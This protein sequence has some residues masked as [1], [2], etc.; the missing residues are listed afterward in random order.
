MHAKGD[1]QQKKIDSDHRR[2]F[3]LSTANYRITLEI[4]TALDV[5]SNPADHHY[6]KYFLC[7][8]L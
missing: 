4:K 3:C 5:L 1:I 7:T 2:Q 8:S 6:P